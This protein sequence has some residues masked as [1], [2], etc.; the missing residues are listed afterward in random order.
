[1]DERKKLILDIII[2]EHIET[3]QPVASSVIVD[4]YQLPYSSAT[5]RNEMAELE[6][7]GW[8]IQPYT[9][10]GRVPTEKAYELFAGSV[11]AKDLPKK[12][13]ALLVTESADEAEGKRLAKQLAQL[14]GLA[15]IWAF[16]KNHVYYTGVSNLLQQ[17]EFAQ[18]HMVYDISAI[19]D[20]VDEI[21][22]DIFETVDF[23][24]SIVLG[25]HSPFGPFSGAILSR[26]RTAQNV[27]LVGVVGPLRMDYEK[28]RSRIAFLANQLSNLS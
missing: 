16:H 4:K 17:P 15:V 13:S 26:Y 24:P 10:A 28:N 5:V 9:S 2:K 12:E 7:A 14:S 6:E 23:S 19:I 20:R 8:I 22:G 1:M 25:R 27:G 21:V 3:G 11:E 18:P